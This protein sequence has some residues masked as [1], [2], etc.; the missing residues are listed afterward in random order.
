MSKKE[1]KRCRKFKKI[2]HFVNENKILKTCCVCRGKD[3]KYKRKKT[4]IVKKKIYNKIECKC[5]KIITRSNYSRHCLSKYHLRY[6]KE[7]DK[8]LFKELIKSDIIKC[9][10]CLSDLRCFC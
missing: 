4:N 6:V 5:G 9:S 2:S 3:K 8:K 7:K 10:V 1:C